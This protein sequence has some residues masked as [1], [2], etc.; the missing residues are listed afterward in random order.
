MCEN[1]PDS[2]PVQSAV[3]PAGNG[4]PVGRRLAIVTTVRRPLGS[5]RTHS[6]NSDNSQEKGT[7]MTET[8]EPQMGLVPLLTT[9]EA[10]DVLRV[11]ERTLWTLT[12]DGEI[13]S[14]R[15]GRSVRYD[16]SDLAAWIA[17]HKTA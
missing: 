7:T 4:F 14:V 15:V 8:D 3:A 1:E 9:R 10:A 5:S 2:N 6:P 16:Q 17:A 13:P 12:H 11:S